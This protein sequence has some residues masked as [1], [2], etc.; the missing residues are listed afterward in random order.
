MSGHILLH[1]ESWYIF[2][3]LLVEWRVV[4][5]AS[6]GLYVNPNTGQTQAGL[7]PFRNRIINGDM[8]INQRSA[9]SPYIV[10][11]ASKYT[12]DRMKGV[13]ISLCSFT[14]I[15]DTDVPLGQ[16]FKYSQK[17]TINTTTTANDW[18][19]QLEHPIEGYNVSD[20]NWGTTNGAYVTLSFW[21]KITGISNG[22]IL[23]IRIEY[24]GTS[25]Y[26][27]NLSYTVV[28]SGNWQYVVL[29]IPPPPT[30]AGVSSATNTTY[31]SILFSLSSSGQGSQQ[32]LNTWAPRTGASRIIGG[33]D[34]AS[35][36]G[37]VRWITGLQLENGPV[38]TPFEARPYPI[39]FQLCQ[40][41]YE[42]ISSYSAIFQ[43]S[44]LYDCTLPYK[45]LKRKG[46]NTIVLSWTIGGNIAISPQIIGNQLD[47]LILRVSNATTNGSIG[48]SASI[49]SEL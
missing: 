1:A 44:A 9:E 18:G 40:R 22:A 41:Y 21:T 30:A 6:S 13:Y 2:V 24:T 46:S 36:S 39:E 8:R 31:L 42:I 19:G 49:D 12:L 37:W 20:F 14:I 10:S 26:S 4:V 23:P 32:T 29:T 25:L 47:S 3:R 38:A 33:T 5:M 16:Q 34:L 15:Q 11:G 27:I 7:Q 45:V 48:G 28:N 17:C 35:T 43:A